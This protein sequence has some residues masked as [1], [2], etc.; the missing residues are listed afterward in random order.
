MQDFQE[1]LLSLVK[2]QIEAGQQAVAQQFQQLQQEQ[3]QFAQQLRAMQVAQSGQAAQAAQSPP[4]QPAGPGHDF[5]AEE[6]E[7]S[8]LTAWEDVL[9]QVRRLPSPGA[10]EALVARLQHAPSLELV[11]AM[12]KDLPGIQGIPET[13]PPRKFYKDRVLWQMQAKQEHIMILLCQAVEQSPVFDGPL[14]SAAALVRSTF[15]DLKD[16]RRKE[17]A[18]REA[19]KLDKR[20]DASSL[21]LLSPAE[22]KLISG[23]RGKGKGKGR[24]RPRGL[25]PQQ[26]QD[27]QGEKPRVWRDYSQHYPRGRGGKGKGRSR[28]AQPKPTAMQE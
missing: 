10:G 6:E 15:E 13:V 24:G 28:S 23:P 16:L 19:Y 5:D 18:G 2:G 7:W 26:A 14:L 1:N 21:R 11:R 4:G 12:Q 25:V 27:P 20:E 22:E 8:S 17:F 9:P 3:A